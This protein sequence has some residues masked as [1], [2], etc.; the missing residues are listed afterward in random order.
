VNKTDETGAPLAGAVFHLTELR[1]VTGGTPELAPEPAYEA[2]SNSAGVV[3]FTAAPGEYILSE[4]SAPTGYDKSD[5][6]WRVWIESGSVYF[7]N[8]DVQSDNG[9]QYS[10]ANPI[11]VVNTS[12]TKLTP[13]PNQGGEDRN[14]PPAPTDTD[15]TLKPGA[16]GSYIEIG[17][18][19][20][21]L[22]EWSWSDNQNQWI[23]DEYPP[24]AGTNP[25]TGSPFGFL[26][27]LLMAAMAA[28]LVTIVIAKRR[29]LAQ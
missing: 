2:T 22:G 28:G 19:G 20:V 24:L 25:K 3:S 8:P 10:Q 6:T 5:E 15:N 13:S 9:R 4:Y 14:T 11:T 12:L 23:F 17:P 26:S 29:R 1:A 21:A 27:R 16:N 18:N 7:Y